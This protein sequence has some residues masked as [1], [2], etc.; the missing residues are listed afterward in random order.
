[1]LSSVL[2]A[3]GA[4]TGGD[5]VTL[6]G[7]N[8]DRHK[9]LVFFNATLLPEEAVTFVSTEE[10]RAIAPPA[11]DA[12]AKAGQSVDISVALAE[13]VPAILQEAYRYD[14]QTGLL[15]V[16]I[17]PSEPVAAGAQWCIDGGEWRNSGATL[18]GL[19]VGEH[20]LSFKSVE[21]WGTPAPRTVTIADGET[22]EVA[23]SYTA[24]SAAV[25]VTIEPAE[26]V[27]A[28]AQWRVDNGEWL[29]SGATVWGLTA[30]EH[31]VSFSSLS[32]WDTP[33][34]QS[35]DLTIGETT[36]LTATYTPHTG[37]VTVTIEPAEAVAAGAQWRVDDGEWLDSGATLDDV[38]VG[39]HTVYFSSVVGWGAPATQP[40]DITIDQ[41]TVL[42]GTY[43]VQSGSITV[44]IEPAEAV[45]AGAQWRV[46]DGEWFDSGATVA[47]LVLRYHTVS[48]SSVEGWGTPLTLVA[49]VTIGQTTVLT[50]TYTSVADSPADV[51]GDGSVNAQDVQLVINAALGIGEENPACDIN[52][53]DTVNA[54]DV[55]L[56]IN[57][58]LGIALNIK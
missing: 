1:M 53:D 43:T 52:S 14:A 15:T 50:G 9:S 34:A 36:P 20:V 55:Q 30:G 26:A 6:L 38:I 54:Q 3:A 44:T 31:T 57:A 29:D 49:V 23:A 27:A 22:T 13:G 19:D 39:Q 47:G 7:A 21:G 41:T 10:L 48:F 28:G 40:A 25:T 16:T 17:A 8:F 37:A 46:D 24:Q 12:G 42:T 4:A 33:L 35:A 58:A 51:S 45:A 56:V 5:E 2:P 32:G 18:S 11:Q